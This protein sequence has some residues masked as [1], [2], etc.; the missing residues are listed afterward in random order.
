MSVL[1]P[2]R[3]CSIVSHPHYCRHY[4]IAG[5]T[6]RI[7]ADRPITNET[8]RKELG[9][10]EVAGPGDDVVFFRHHFALPHL[11]ADRLGR[12]VYRKPPWIIYRQEDAWVYLGIRPGLDLPVLSQVGILNSDHTDGDI[13]SA[14][15]TMFRAGQLGSLGLFSRDQVILAHVLADRQGCYFHG[16]GVILEG[17]G[18]LFVGHS[19]AGKSTI[20]KMLQDEAEI[21]CDDRIVVRRWTEGFRIHGT[22][23]H[24][25]VPIVSPKSAPLRALFM[26]EKAHTN[27]IIPIPDRKE[28]VRRLPFYVTK[29]LVTADWWE[30]TF[31][32]LA[33]LVRE[34]PVYRLQFDRSGGVK[35]LLRAL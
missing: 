26:L 30:K 32:L 16:A 17:Q 13:Y 19:E 5:L 2:D 15:D 24:S 23:N 29:A 14:D 8:F 25:A 10:F 12:E 6:I 34:V 18:L 31:D 4:G 1:D 9:A 7:Q 28:V 20:A 3:A 11:Q 33:N 27:R 22:W 35:D 21:L